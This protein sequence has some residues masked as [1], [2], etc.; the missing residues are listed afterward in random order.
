MR[1]REL[2]PR[3]AEARLGQAGNLVDVRHEMS[4]ALARAAWGLRDE[5]SFYDALYVG[6]AA[7]LQRPLLISDQRLAAAA[8]RHCEVITLS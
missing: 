8:R 7:A 3:V 5:V 4:G 6:L 2:E 1:R